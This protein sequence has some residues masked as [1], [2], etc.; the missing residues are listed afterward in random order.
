[1]LAPPMPCS[2]DREW[3]AYLHQWARHT[4]YQPYPMG[5]GFLS[6][7]K[8]ITIEYEPTELVIDVRDS[9]SD[10]SRRLV[11]GVD[12]VR[13]VRDLLYAFDVVPIEFSSAYGVGVAVGR[14]S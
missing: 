13:T 2:T 5:G 14:L 7:D 9:A 8:A 3:L 12:S 11:A 6:A 10:F 1:M 4:G